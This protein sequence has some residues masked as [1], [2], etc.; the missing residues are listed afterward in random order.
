MSFGLKSNLLKISTNLQPVLAAKAHLA[1]EKLLQETLNIVKK[2][3]NVP[4][5][6]INTECFRR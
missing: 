5:R 4:N 2:V 3:P 6:D 1:E